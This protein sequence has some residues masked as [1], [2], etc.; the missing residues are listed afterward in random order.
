MHHKFTMKDYHWSTRFD[1]GYHTQWKIQLMVIPNTHLMLHNTHLQPTCMHMYTHNVDNLRWCSKHQCRLR[2][3]QAYNPLSA[4][5]H[6][7]T[8]TPARPYTHM[9][10]HTPHTCTHSLCMH[11][12]FGKWYDVGT[13][14]RL[15]PNG[16]SSVGVVVV[17]LLIVL[18]IELPPL[19]VTHGLPTGWR[20]SGSFRHQPTPHWIRRVLS[21]PC[22]QP[23]TYPCMATIN[24]S[25]NWEIVLHNF[26][27]PRANFLKADISSETMF[28]KAWQSRHVRLHSPCT[29]TYMF[30]THTTQCCPSSNDNRVPRWQGTLH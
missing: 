8:H 19:V 14:S 10:T 23:H 16:S 25:P 12:Q 5:T 28:K 17:V 18:V 30:D 2:P 22:S 6:T 24:T 21:L 7:H 15:V 26:I 3:P 9:H 20:D 4:D 27:L 11:L 29:C 13:A 1:K